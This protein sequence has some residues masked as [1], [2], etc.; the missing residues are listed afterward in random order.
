MANHIVV[1]DSLDQFGVSIGPQP[2]QVNGRVF[3]P[4]TI[5]YH[6]G[7]TSR[8]AQGSWKVEPRGRQQ[9][10]QPARLASF[11][12]VIG[13]GRVDPEAVYHFL[14][15]MLGEARSLG[16]SVPEVPG[17]PAFFA[18]GGNSMDADFAEAVNQA[19]QA[20]NKPPELIFAVFESTSDVYD[21]FKALGL[22]Q[23]VAT[24]ALKWDKIRNKTRD[25][26]T[27]VNIALKLK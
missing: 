20:F 19:N 12:V 13:P 5:E 27:Q 26:Q 24:Q 23:G 4:P 1:I 8:V 15:A 2:K 11:G 6:R 9:L 14:C 25:F 7:S 17:N 18:R 3:T 21:R 22:M 10:L 16:L